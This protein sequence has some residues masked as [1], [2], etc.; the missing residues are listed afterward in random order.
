MQLFSMPLSDFV[1]LYAALSP[2][3][4]VWV[5]SM[6]FFQCFCKS[7]LG[8]V[9]VGFGLAQCCCVNA[10]VSFC[11]GLLS[12]LQCFC[13]LLVVAM[14][15]LNAS[16]RFSL[17]L[18]SFSMLLQAFTLLYAVISFLASCYLVAFIFQAFASFHLSSCFRCSCQASRGPI[19]VFEC[20]CK[21]LLGSIVLG[22]F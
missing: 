18:R 1:W 21:L 7:L 13:L 19:F 10:V 16:A 22:H 11:L 2:F 12:L 20:F 8:N 3:L 6:R 15:F 4:L 5:G 14:Q 17:L 9:F